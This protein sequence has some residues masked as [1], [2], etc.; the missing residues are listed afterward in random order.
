MNDFTYSIVTE[1]NCESLCVKELKN[2]FGVVASANK[3]F[4]DFCAYFSQSATRVLLKIGSGSFNDLDDLLL[5]I[6]SDLK[7]NDAWFSLLSNTFKSSCSRLG[8]HDFNSV[9]VEQEVSNV[10]RKEII[11]KGGSST[12]DYKSRELVFFVLI[13]DD[14]YLLGVDFMGKD[15]SKRHYLIFN[16][17]NAIKGTIAFNLLLFSGFEPG[18][19]LLDGFALAGVIPIEA[20]I[21]EKGASVNLFSKDFLFP[22]KLKDINESLLSKFDSEVQEFKKSGNIFSCDASFPNL[23]AQKK[24]SRIAGVEKNISFARVD[25]ANLDIKN[26]SKEIDV[27]CSR[28][29]E[30]SKHVPESRVVKAY[31]DFFVAAKEFLGKKGSVNVIVRVPDLLEEIAK[32]HGFKVKDKLETAQGQQVFFFVKLVK[33]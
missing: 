23:A 8:V 17:P 27:A 13:N 14:N 25:I 12:P 33:Y 29:L 3:G 32:K 2:R 20:A 10:V 4:V 19:V 7:N 16:N 5:K 30:V 24:N 28:I 11:S 6:G 26:F 22:L 18:M 31:N 1:K 9:I 21:Y 15:L